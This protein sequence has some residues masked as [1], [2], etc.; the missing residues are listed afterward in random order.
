MEQN[1]QSEKMKIV[2][3]GKV[4]GPH[5][6]RKK[7]FPTNLNG[8]WTYDQNIENRATPALTYFG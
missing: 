3:S 7:Y 1:L 5:L 2:V 4:I 8:S 6:E